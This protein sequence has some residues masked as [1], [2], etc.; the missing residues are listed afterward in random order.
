MVVGHLFFKDIHALHLYYLHQSRLFQTHVV[1]FNFMYS[2]KKK[3]KKISRQKV[4][5]GGGILIGLSGGKVQPSLSLFLC[6]DVYRE[7]I[8]PSQVFVPATCPVSQW[9][10]LSGRTAVTVTAHLY[11]YS[12]QKLQETDNQKHQHSSK[13]VSGR[14]GEQP[15]PQQHKAA[16]R[17]SGGSQVRQAGTIQFGGLPKEQTCTQRTFGGTF[18]VQR[19]GNIQPPL[20]LV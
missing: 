4:G 15:A 19:R 18:S 8:L 20:A 6:V 12:I 1:Y 16:A 17:C 11:T 9:H 7:E 2:V 13:A 10:T 3:K 5:G 14:Q